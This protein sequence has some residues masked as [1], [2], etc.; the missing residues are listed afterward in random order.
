MTKDEEAAYHTLVKEK[1][2]L[3]SLAVSA[4]AHITGVIPFTPDFIVAAAWP[5]RNS[6]SVKKECEFCSVE[7]ALSPFSQAALEKY[8]S[9]KIACIVCVS[10]IDEEG[11]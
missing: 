5:S 11:Q 1:G 6:E 3:E 10:K 2:F 7:V 9:A 4:K 8:P